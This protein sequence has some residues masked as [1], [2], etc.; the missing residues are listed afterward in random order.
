MR[1]IRERE[2]EREG[3]GRIGRVGFSRL[4]YTYRFNAG[5]SSATSA[6]TDCWAGINLCG[7]LG[8]AFILH[9]AAIEIKLNHR[10]N[11]LNLIKVFFFFFSYAFFPNII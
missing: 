8:W 10:S 11:V 7:V 9:S 3:K 4:L 2:R 1:A 5:A 6:L